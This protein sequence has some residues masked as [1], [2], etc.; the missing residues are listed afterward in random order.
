VIGKAYIAPGY[1]G[2]YGEEID[3]LLE[4]YYSEDETNVSKDVD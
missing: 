2:V 4:E 1:T 3:K